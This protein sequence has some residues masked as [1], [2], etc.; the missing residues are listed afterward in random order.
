MADFGLRAGQAERLQCGRT[1]KVGFCPL[2]GSGLIGQIQK[3][4]AAAM[5]I[6]EK[7]V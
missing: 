2:L 5:H 4:T 6:A 3:M 1:L 7:K